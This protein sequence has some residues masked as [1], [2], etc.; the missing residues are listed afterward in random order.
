MSK[1][2]DNIRGDLTGKRFASTYGRLIGATIDADYKKLSSQELV[3]YEIIFGG[4]IITKCR[5]EDRYNM[6]NNVVRQIR[7]E[8]YGDIKNR[9]INL[10]RAFYEEN[11]QEVQSQLR[12][13]MKEIFG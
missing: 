13:I 12:D 1:V 9:I 8:L 3:E 6:L 10:E 2:I 5:T 7:E 11:Y 4:K